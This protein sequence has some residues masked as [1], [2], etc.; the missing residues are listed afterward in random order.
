VSAVLGSGPLPRPRKLGRRAAEALP[1]SESASLTQGNEY[2]ANVGWETERIAALRTQARNATLVGAAGVVVAVLGLVAVVS[3]E[4]ARQFIP[5]PIV[6]DRTTGE[7]TAAAPLAPGSVPAIE[8]IDKASVAKFVQA[9]EGYAWDFLQRDYNAVGRMASP[10]VF[11]T[12]NA[13]FD[14]P[15]AL[16]KELGAGVVWRIRVLSVRLDLDTVKRKGDTRGGE[17]VV[18]YEKDVRDVARGLSEPPTRHVATLRYEY[19]PKA[20]RTEADRLDNPLGF[21]VTAY[22]TDTELRK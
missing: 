19:Q 13:Q 5:V 20:M 4:R 2:A 22:R 9:R 15:K 10:E 12:F 21:V 6:V 3:I 1:S 11:K 14:G 17:A 8:A 18:T 16:D 7:T